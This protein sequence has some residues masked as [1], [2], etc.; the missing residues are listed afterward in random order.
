MIE[1][2]D[3]CFTLI[4][5]VKVDHSE[6]PRLDVPLVIFTLQKNLKSE[7]LFD[8]FTTCQVHSSNQLE[9]RVDCFYVFILLTI[10]QQ[11]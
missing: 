11:Q 9:V 8:R 1:V 4:V 5:D 3:R 2:V 10:T 7:L 6:A